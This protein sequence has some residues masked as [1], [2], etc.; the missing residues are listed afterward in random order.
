MTMPLDM[1]PHNHI[2]NWVPLDDLFDGTSD[3]VL[4]VCE[5]CQHTTVYSLR[6]SGMLFTLEFDTPTEAYAYLGGLSGHA[7]NLSENAIQEAD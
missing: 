1:L 7:E 6:L 3:Y 2:D 4:G 5:G